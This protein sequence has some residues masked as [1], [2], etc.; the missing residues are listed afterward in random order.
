MLYALRNAKFRFYYS[1]FPQE[2]RVAI[3]EDS[4]DTPKYVKSK[5][6]SNVEVDVAQQENFQHI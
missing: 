6:Y 1:Q 3:Y 4:K 5:I 2:L